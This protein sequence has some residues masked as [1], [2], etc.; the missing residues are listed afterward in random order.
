MDSLDI[1]ISKLDLVL[2]LRRD[3]GTMTTCGETLLVLVN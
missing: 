2:T 1:R 3:V